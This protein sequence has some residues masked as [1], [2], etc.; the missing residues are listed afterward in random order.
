[1]IPFKC[2]S[3]QQEMSAP[4]SMAGHFEECPACKV[5]VAVPRPRDLETEMLTTART[6]RA[7]VPASR[8]PPFDVGR[9]SQLVGRPIAAVGLLGIAF[10][11]LGAVL[12]LV[13]GDP[14]LVSL[15]ISR[16]ASLLIEAGI[17]PFLVGLALS[18]LG[19]VVVEL[20]KIR[21]LLEVVDS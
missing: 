6:K 13:V 16:P 4:D 7:C 9:M 21:I 8:K 1:M 10:G 3:C 11:V 15:A 12:G 14:E 17:T 5:L 20:K 18:S 2:Q 19:S